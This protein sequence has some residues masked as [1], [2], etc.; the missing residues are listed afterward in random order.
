MEA[1]TGDIELSSLSNGI[2]FSG[3][4]T[5]ILHS[6][7]TGRLTSSAINLASG[8]VTGIL[9]V[10]NGGSPFTE[11]NGAIFERITTQD[12]LLG[13]ATTQ[14]AQFAIT[15]VATD[16]PVAT[17][18]GSNNNGIVLNAANSSIQSLLNNT[19]TLGGS[20]YWRYRVK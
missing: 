5:G 2:V 3:Y 4:S 14:S 19:L 18:S 7:S 9:P 6:D 13:G 11:G 20:N 17:L 16:T 15:G 12:F 8:D 10:V 1:T